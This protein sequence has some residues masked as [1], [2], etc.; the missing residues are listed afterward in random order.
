MAARTISMALV[1]ATAAQAEP[2]TFFARLIGGKSAEFWKFFKFGIV[3]NGLLVLM[4]CAG[5]GLDDLIAKWLRTPKGWGALIGA[6]VG[7]SISD[8]IAGMADGRAAAI[9][10]ALGALLPVLPVMISASVFKQRADNKQNQL[11][12]M[13]VSALMV[14][15]SFWKPGK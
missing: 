8:G 5:V 15:A 7:N 14:A 1:A 12:L 6:C 4:T 3:D 2:G 11:V 13:A 10:V 9:G